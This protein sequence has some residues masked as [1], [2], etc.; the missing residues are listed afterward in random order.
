MLTYLI[1]R[2]LTSVFLLW[3]VVTLTFLLIHVAPGDP[4]D[5]L[6]DPSV[7]NEDA[8][9]L[10]AR[11]GL[12]ASLPEQYV[13][14]LGGVVQGDLGISL[15]RQRPVAEVLLEALPHTLRLTT[16]SLGLM[17]GVGIALGLVAAL[18]R[19]TRWDR[20]T[21]LGSLALYSAPVFWLSLMAQLL[22]SVKLGWLPTGGTG[23][24]DVV[25]SDPTTWLGVDPRHLVLPVA[26]L[27]L[28]SAAG[29][30]RYV[31]GSVLEVLGQEYI[32]T[33]HAKGMPPRQVVTRHVLR[34]AA[35]PVVT[36]LGLHLPFLFGGAV[37]VETLFA[38]PGMGRVAVDAIFSRDYP[39]ILATTMFSGALVVLG[40]LLADL[41]YAWIDPRVRLR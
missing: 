14:W 22:F 3:G 30:A 26:I 20:W 41:G 36:L 33:A 24:V 27:G 23:T 16:L 37:V 25:A 19:G 15:R 6:L 35:M 1:R 7:P 13:R 17:Y 21:T 5:L 10:R 29:V 11:F 12:D 4:V 9:A 8:D 34:N 40:S 31:R 18:R 2:L 38:W 39:V 32:R 28:T